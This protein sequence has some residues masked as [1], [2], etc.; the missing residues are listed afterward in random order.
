MSQLYVTGPFLIKQT[1]T[2]AVVSQYAL[3][4]SLKVWNI[5]VKEFLQDKKQNVAAITEDGKGYYTVRCGMSLKILKQYSVLYN[6]IAWLLKVKKVSN[7]V[8]KIVRLHV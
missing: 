2:L 5:L 1:Q 4:L 6:W 8:A 7:I 3:N